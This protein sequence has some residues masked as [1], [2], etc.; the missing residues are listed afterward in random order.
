MDV[1][2]QTA[3]DLVQWYAGLPLED[4]LRGTWHKD[5]LWCGPTGIVATYT[6]ERYSKQHSGPFRASF[7]D[8]SKTNHICRI[9]EGHYGAFFGWPNFTATPT[10]GFMGMPATDKPGEFR[11]IDVYRREG[12]KLKENWIFIDLLHFW[13]GQGVDILKRTIGIEGT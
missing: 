3:K 2:A 5:M 7:G 1:I 10:G 6:I 11:V 8:R 13:K 4:E 9:G 12:E